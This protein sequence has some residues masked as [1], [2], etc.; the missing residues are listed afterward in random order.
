MKNQNK[1]SCWNVTKIDSNAKPLKH[2]TG[3][4]PHPLVKS[5]DFFEYFETYTFDWNYKHWLELYYN[6]LKVKA[7][8]K[9]Y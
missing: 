1:G 4:E 2:I 6:D 9:P 5:C 7:F 3:N 8:K